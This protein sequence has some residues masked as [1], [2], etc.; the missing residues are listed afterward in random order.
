MYVPLR[1]V[2]SGNDPF[3]SSSSFFL[4]IDDHSIFIISNDNVTHSK[5]TRSH[6]LH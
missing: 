5:L 4:V 2:S 1:P 3:F 6:F